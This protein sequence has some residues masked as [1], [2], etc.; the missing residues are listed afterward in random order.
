[1]SAKE[2]FEELGY[3]CDVSC[4]GILYSKYV[5]LPNGNVANSQIEFD[6]VDKIVEKY[7]SQAGFSMKFYNSK[8]TL[9]EL[10]AIN[11]QVEELG[12]NK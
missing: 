12:W 7:V 8:I 6:N 1:M 3:E 4:D 10:K 11:K 2:T 5:D 9:D